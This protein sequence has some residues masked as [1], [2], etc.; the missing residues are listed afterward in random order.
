VDDAIGEYR[1]AIRLNPDLVE[2]YFNLGSLLK[3]I[4]QTRE[5]ADA[6][7]EYVRRAPNT[8]ANQLWIEQAQTFLEKARERRHEGDGRQGSGS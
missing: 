7:R 8:S 6:F 1:T 3:E 4:N 5:A 2:A